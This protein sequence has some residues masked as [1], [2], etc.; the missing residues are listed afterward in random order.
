MEQYDAIIIGSGLGG[1]ECGYILARHGM[2]V[3]VL[4]RH[5]QP[6][7]CLQ[8]FQRGN[9]RFDTGFHYVGG[10]GEGQPLHRLFRY[11]GL[12]D[13]PWYPL[14]EAAFDEVVFDGKTYAFANG[15]ERFADTL[16]RHFPARRGELAAYAAFLKHVGEHLF[17]AFTPGN[18]DSLYTTS[19]FA[20]SAYDFLKETTDDPLLRKILSGTSLKMELCAGTLP[21]YV[22]AQINSAFIQSAWRLRGGGSQIAERLSQQLRAMGGEVRTRAEATRLTEAGGRLA[23]VEVNGEEQLSARW[24]ISD[25]HPACTL[26]LADETKLLRNI[27]RKRIASLPNTFGMFTLHLRLKPGRVPYRNRNVFVHDRLS[28]GWHDRPEDGTRSVMISYYPPEAG[29]SCAPALDILSPMSWSEVAPWKDLPSGRR[30]ESYEQLK[31]DRAEACIRL[32]S[33][34][35][36]GLRDAVEK[37]YTSSPLSYRSYTNAVEGSAYGIR[38]DYTR[39][40]YTLLTPRTPIPNLL[41][42]GQNLNLHGILGVSVTSFFTCAEILGREAATGGLELT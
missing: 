35:I 24:V 15:Y 37:M 7:G 19:L 16:A 31:A 20:Q 27:Y 3:C 13:L 42:T 38:K 41:L 10:L 18:A 22:F 26:A 5:A 34:Q 11:F 9:V 36:P 28:D 17:D 25:V 14:D 2:K 8:T 32:A 21:L 40:M 29:S 33:G 39:P 4:E 1:L 6:G 30:G 23:T 12:L